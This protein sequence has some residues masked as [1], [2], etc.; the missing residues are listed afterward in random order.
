VAATAVDATPGRALL[1]GAHGKDTKQSD[2][3]D[4]QVI[5]KRVQMTGPTVFSS[6]MPAA[7]PAG[8]TRPNKPNANP[9]GH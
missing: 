7:K 3:S 4:G 2:K 9:T 1:H 6:P 8:A 5:D